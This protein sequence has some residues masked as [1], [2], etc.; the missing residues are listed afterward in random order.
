MKTT[1]PDRMGAHPQYYDLK[2][3][4]GQEVEITDTSGLGT[5]QPTGV[6][7]GGKSPYDE[8]V[9]INQ[10]RIVYSI[11]HYNVSRIEDNQ[12]IVEAGERNNEIH[13]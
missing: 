3:L 6:L 7:R 13:R 10:D 5:A 8:F 2:A 1:T 4:Y 11:P 12:I 9:I